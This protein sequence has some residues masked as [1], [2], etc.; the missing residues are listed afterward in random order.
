[1]VPHGTDTSPS[2]VRQSRYGQGWHP[3]HAPAAPGVRIPSDARPVLILFPEMGD[4][5]YASP[6]C[7]G[8]STAA[9]SH[10]LA[11]DATPLCQPVGCLCVCQAPLDR[12]F[13]FPPSAA[14]IVFRRSSMSMSFVLGVIPPAA[15]P[16]EPRSGRSTLTSPRQ[17]KGPA[18]TEGKG[19]ISTLIVCPGL[20]DELLE[21][22]MGVKNQAASERKPDRKPLPAGAFRPRSWSAR[23]GPP[24]AVSGTAWPPS[25]SS[26]RRSWSG[27][28]CCRGC[29]P[30]GSG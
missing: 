17:R 23:H 3:D 6:A 30:S 26:P 13:P 22:R 16:R 11:I 8:A 9:R 14:G 2:S 21:G 10:G 15:A 20:G 25:G 12:E 29:R 5:L 18:A 24:G 28:R 7:L 4:S 27:S 1:M 19:A